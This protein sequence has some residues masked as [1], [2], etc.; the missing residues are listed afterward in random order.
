MNWQYL[1]PRELAKMIQKILGSS[2]TLSFVFCFTFQIYNIFLTFQ[3]W[4]KLKISLITGRTDSTIINT[5]VLQ[6]TLSKSGRFLDKWV[7]S[8]ICEE[9]PS[10]ILPAPIFGNSLV[11]KLQ[12]FLYSWNIERWKTFNTTVYFIKNEGHNKKS[13]VK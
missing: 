13:R 7:S 12:F 8:C 4:N 9:V 11:S 1:W 3:R 5:F 6:T 2:E 10:K